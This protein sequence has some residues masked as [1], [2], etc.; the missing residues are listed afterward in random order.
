[1][2]GT[3]A[4]YS[5]V[6]KKPTLSGS[7]YSYSNDYSEWQKSRSVLSS[8]DNLFILTRTASYGN[9]STDGNTIFKVQPFDTDGSF[10]LGSVQTPRA[11]NLDM[12][13]SSPQT[14]RYVLAASASV[15]VTSLATS[16][17]DNI[18]NLVGRDLIS[19]SFDKVI[20]TIDESGNFD[21]S[22]ITNNKY[23]ALTIVRL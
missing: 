4:D 22:T 16:L 23:T 7:S 15:W 5:L 11:A 9:S 2:S 12:E 14:G 18:V 13:A 3:T 21:K 1:L 8:K 6:V 19:D 20:G 17:K 10:R